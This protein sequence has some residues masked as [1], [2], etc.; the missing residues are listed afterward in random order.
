VLA[1]E[2]R[3]DSDTEDHCD[4]LVRPAVEQSFSGR[5]RDGGR[6]ARRGVPGRRSVRA[7]ILPRELR[8]VGID[9]RKLWA[10]MFEGRD[11]HAREGFDPR[12]SKPPAGVSYLQPRWA[13]SA[14]SRPTG[15]T[16]C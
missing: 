16:S 2:C 1:H 10:D 8:E 15:C 7:P 12:S 11:A 3:D 9:E 13:G 14:D 5:G 6:H 4:C